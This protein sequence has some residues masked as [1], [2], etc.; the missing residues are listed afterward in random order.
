MSNEE[1]VL[2]KNADGHKQS[3]VKIRLQSLCC[4]MELTL[5]DKALG[6][7][8]GVI[9][10]SSN[11]LGKSVDVKYIEALISA[12]DIT[13]K[14]NTYNLGASIREGARD[15]REKTLTQQ[16]ISE[17]SS[18]RTFWVAA[19]ELIA[20]TTCFITGNDN[21]IAAAVL[22]GIA[23]LMQKT[24]SRAI[25]TMSVSGD[26]QTL[27]LLASMGA[28]YMGKTTEAVTMLVLYSTTHVLQQV[29]LSVARVKVDSCGAS[30]LP[31]TATLHSTGK[32]VPISSLRP[33]TKIFVRAGE[34]IPADGTVFKDSAYVDEAAVTGESKPKRKT[35]GSEVV[36][37]GI[38]QDGALGMFSL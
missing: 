10:Y 36:S 20:L 22:I 17:I 8:Q 26:M 13:A 7:E 37:G 18:T 6:K 11:I 16:I 1:T 35:V 29:V 23:D 27:M 33:G 4:E 34:C 3:R 32:D 19:G 12:A 21:Y 14:L 15:G 9:G 38:I 24:L 2:L 30:V 31:S 28:L 5:V 25:S